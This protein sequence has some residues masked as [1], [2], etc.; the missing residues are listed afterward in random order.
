MTKN[1]SMPGGLV[2]LDTGALAGRFDTKLKLFQSQFVT[3]RSRF[4]TH[5][6]SIQ[7]KLKSIFDTTL[8]DTRQPETILQFPRLNLPSDT[9]QFVPP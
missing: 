2:A 5:L 4:D 8:K 1:Q 6:K 9:G 3:I 7:C